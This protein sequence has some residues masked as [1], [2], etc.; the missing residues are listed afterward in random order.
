[1][2]K[3]PSWI[4]F[5]I[6]GEVVV[7]TSIPGSSR[8]HQFSRLRPG[9]PGLPL[10]VNWLGMMDLHHHKQSQSLRYFCYTNPQK[11]LVLQE[12]LEPSICQFTKLVLLP[13]S[14]CSKWCLRRDSNSQH[15][16][17]E[18]DDSSSWPTQAK[19]G[20]SERIRTST[21]WSLKPLTLPVGPRM[22]L[23]VSKIGPERQGLPLLCGHTRHHAS[24][25]LGTKSWVLRCLATPA[26]VLLF[27]K[28]HL[29][30]IH[31]PCIII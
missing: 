14:H 13:L 5:P 26:P 11:N 8:Y 31:Q 20:A 21:V 27:I 4:T 24:A 12:G 19:N 1:M 23:L 16:C 17:A 9:P 7:P 6:G 22:Q 25:S 18:H 10:H 2:A 3:T 15:S 28:Q 30:K 29:S